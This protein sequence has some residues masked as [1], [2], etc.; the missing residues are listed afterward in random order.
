MILLDR[1]ELMDRKLDGRYQHVGDPAFDRYLTG[2]LDL[3]I[4]I[5]AA[6]GAHVVAADRAVHAPGGAAG[7]RPLRRRTGPTRVDAWNRLLRRRPPTGDD[8]TVLDLNRRVCPDGRFTWE[9]RRAA[10]PQRRPA[11]HPG[12]GAAS[13]SPRGCCP[14]ST[15]SPCGADDRRIA[16]RGG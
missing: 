16:V 10:G 15:G 8:V 14:S 13:G 4:C 7:R 9:H 12:G 6:R 2:E 11:L 5:A 1:W 3:A